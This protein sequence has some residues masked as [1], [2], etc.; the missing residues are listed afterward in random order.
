VFQA[1]PTRRRRRRAFTLIE[2]LVVIAIIAILIGLLVPAVQKVRAAAARIQCANNLKQI[3][4]AFHNYHDALGLFPDGGKNGSDPPV[5]NPNNTSSPSGRAE[6]SWPWQILPFVEQDN[7]HNLKNTTAN[8]NLIAKTPVKIYYCPARRAPIVYNGKAKIDYAGC[9][10]T[11]STGA[12][13]VVVRMGVGSV[14]IADITDGTS[15]TL[16]VGEKRLKRDKFGVSTDDNESCYAPGWD[17][18]IFRRAVKDTD[19]PCCGPNPDVVR[20]TDPP[21][22]NPNSSLVQFGSSHTGG[23]NGVLADGS[24]RLIRYNPNATAFKNLCVRNDGK[25]VNLNDF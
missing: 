21:F 6:W 4:L 18:D 17:E 23:M 10:G 5:S 11:S 20:T 7:L 3:G 8:N 13:G 24:V 16:M 25:V 14:R 9:A 15:N 2:L 12:N 22:T 19:Q 1:H